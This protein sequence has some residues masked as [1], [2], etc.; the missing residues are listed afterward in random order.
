M[1]YN[2]NLKNEI[3]SL[4]GS[5]FFTKFKPEGPIYTSL[6]E[7]IKNPNDMNA[8]F[9]PNSPIYEDC[10]NALCQNL[11]EI[12]THIVEFMVI[13]YDF[14]VDGLKHFTEI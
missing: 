13:L 4:N 2:L 11:E 5:I 9:N 14:E 1:V 6:M 8:L 10:V 7:F 3:K 12:I